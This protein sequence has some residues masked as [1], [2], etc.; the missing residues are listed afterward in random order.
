MRHCHL[1]ILDFNR[2]TCPESLDGGKHQVG[3][4]KEKACLGPSTSWKRKRS[5]CLLT[6]LNHANG[7]QDS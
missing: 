6:Q 5:L 4:E 2:E 3:R 7:S 1:T